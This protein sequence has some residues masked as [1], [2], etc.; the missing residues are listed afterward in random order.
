MHE[1]ILR[2]ILERVKSYSAGQDDKYPLSTI[3]DDP[4]Y[5]GYE[6]G[7]DAFDL[8]IDTLA[9]IEEEAKYL[10]LITP[11]GHE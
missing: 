3:L 9:K 2:K 10:D 4:M 5:F 8:L 6:T 1:T 7:N 11:T